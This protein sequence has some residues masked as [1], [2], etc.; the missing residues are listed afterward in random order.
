MRKHFFK[1][2]GAAVLTSALLLTTGVSAVPAATAE[3]EASVSAEDVRAA[4]SEVLNG[5]ASQGRGHEL[6][7]AAAATYQ[8]VYQ[9]EDL[10]YY[11]LYDMTGDGVPELFVLIDVSTR[12][13]SE[14]ATY[15]YSVNTGSN[16]VETVRSNSSFVTNSLL[17]PNDGNG[18]LSSAVTS[19]AEGVE[20]YAYRIT[21][22]GSDVMK[23]NDAAYHE[24]IRIGEDT[25]EGKL[26]V[27]NLT[28]RTIAADDLTA[29]VYAE[30]ASVGASAAGK[31][32][33]AQG[34]G[35]EDGKITIY[36]AYINILE[37]YKDS[38]DLAAEY[39]T[40]RSTGGIGRQVVVT[41]VT[42]DGVPELIFNRD[43]GHSG[44]NLGFSVYGI[45]DDQVKQIYY[46]ELG[47]DVGGSCHYVVFQ[48]EEGGSLHVMTD[49]GD[50]YQEVVWK[51]L[52]QGEF[53]MLDTIETLTDRTEYYENQSRDCD[54]NGTAISAEECDQLV[55]NWINNVY[56]VH[57]YSRATG[58]NSTLKAFAESGK[59]IGQNC[60]K[61]IEYLKYMIEKEGDQ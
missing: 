16:G 57:M 19:S 28:T 39:L 60:D 49:I 46:E 9:G 22:Q 3:T 2:A 15:V 23:E 47:L 27:K 58:Y 61:T 18:I 29:E 26:P 43:L 37:Q 30:L 55:S 20:M 10:G 12:K 59:V 51:T 13:F 45:V 25:V 7:Q 44:A 17:A 8:S 42:D 5:I 1:K 54:L 48:M 21:M 31:T 11:T 34:S 32:T 33:D 40:T 35:T 52:V 38:I 50:E 53:G 4:Y 36:Q 41:D 6:F 24:T 56:S 14:F